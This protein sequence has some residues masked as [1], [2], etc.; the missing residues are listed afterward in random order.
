MEYVSFFTHSFI[1]HKLIC[2]RVS[3][4]L[5]IWIKDKTEK[6]DTIII[7][8]QDRA[9]FSLKR[10]IAQKDFFFKRNDPDF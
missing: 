7:Y 2:H 3:Q 10:T 1:F 9:N 5:V 4:K 8:V 6:K